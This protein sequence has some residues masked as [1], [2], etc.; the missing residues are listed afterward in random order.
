M[1]SIIYIMSLAS[2][3][4]IQA[5]EFT[6]KALNVQAAVAGVNKVTLTATEASAEYSVSLPAAAPTAGKALMAT[7]AGV[8]DWIVPGTEPGVA[9][10]EPFGSILTPQATNLAAASIITTSGQTAHDWTPA[11]L[12]AGVIVRKT[13]GGT[14][15]D[16]LHSTSTSAGLI[17]ELNNR[18]PSR[19]VQDGDFWDLTI[20]KDNGNSSINWASRATF[21][22]LSATHAGTPNTELL[23]GNTVT[24]RF[25]VSNTAANIIVFPVARFT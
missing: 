13:A 18:F 12:F 4:V 8:L 7:S 25:L 21:T 1:Y 19:A 15:T 11:Q 20:I 24:L 9:G 2:H 16:T 22:D 5:K 14:P 23:A 17:A 6:S 3:G 10:P